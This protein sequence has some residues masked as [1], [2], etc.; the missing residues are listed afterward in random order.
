MS[1]ITI[2]DIED[3]KKAIDENSIFPSYNVSN[4]E[5]KSLL[6]GVKVWDLVEVETSPDNFIYSQ[7]VG[8]SGG[9]VHTA[10]RHRDGKIY[11]FSYE[12][13]TVIEPDANSVIRKIIPLAPKGSA[14]WRNQML[15]LGKKLRNSKWN[16]KNINYCYLYEGK[17][18][19]EG[20][21]T[22]YM[23]HG[24]TLDEYDIPNGWQI[25]EPETDQ[26]DTVPSDALHC[27][28]EKKCVKPIPDLIPIPEEEKPLRQLMQDARAK[29]K[30]IRSKCEDMVFA[31][32]TLVKYLAEGYLRWWNIRNWELTNRKP[33][34]FVK[35]KPE[36]E[37]K[38]VATPE[39][40]VDEPRFDV[41][42]LTTDSKFP[43]TI[44][45]IQDDTPMGRY[46]KYIF[47]EPAEYPH[48]WKT[49]VASEIIDDIES[50][51]HGEVRNSD[52]TISVHCSRFEIIGYPV[53][54]QQEIEPKVDVETKKEICRFCNGTG[55]S[56]RQPSN[57][58]N[59]VCPYCLDKILREMHER[60]DRDM[61][62]EPAP[63]SRSGSL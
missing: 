16:N 55:R 1:K 19:Y 4:T 32:E 31:P 20:R 39:T 49:Q 46:N 58:S 56:P 34:M 40:P 59:V 17:V 48:L 25:Y 11:Y 10:S 28:T 6:A 44:R 5:E 3:A 43:C 50:T 15:L 62:V 14:K 42:S 41:C 38:L 29:G 51:H 13:T 47:G 26:Y 54:E 52:G 23:R 30:N 35:K 36:P 2:E 21:N 27:N 37:P 63:A 18:C 22:K 9:F 57:A 33:N 45:L 12:M 24:L 60:M 53:D 61:T 7:V 8:I